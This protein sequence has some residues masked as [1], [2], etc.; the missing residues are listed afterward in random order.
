MPLTTRTT[1]SALARRDA[2]TAFHVDALLTHSPR[3]PISLALPGQ[4]RGR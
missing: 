4:S 1:K 3:R 2:L